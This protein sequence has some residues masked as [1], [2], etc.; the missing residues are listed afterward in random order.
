[1]N[2]KEV[3]R[4]VIDASLTHDRKTQTQLLRRHCNAIFIVC[5]PTIDK[6]LSQIETSLLLCTEIFNCICDLSALLIIKA[7]LFFFLFLWCPCFT[8]FLFHIVSFSLQFD[9]K[10][11]IARRS[12]EDIHLKNSKSCWRCSREVKDL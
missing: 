6:G 3:S 5:L 7:F 1:M 10:Q 2:S 11:W 9:S 12:A 8:T 4:K